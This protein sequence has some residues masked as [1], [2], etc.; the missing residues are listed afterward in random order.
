[1]DQEAIV[2]TISRDMKRTLS[3]ETL[4]DRLCLPLELYNLVNKSQR[5]ND[6]F[7]LLYRLI[8]LQVL[9][10]SVK[11]DQLNNPL[12]PYQVYLIEKVPLEVFGSQ[13]GS[14]TFVP[15]K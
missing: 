2:Q 12:L 8:P 13:D 10:P 3:L 9:S 1:M 4:G 6:N 14:K 11:V 15:P 5:N 7:S